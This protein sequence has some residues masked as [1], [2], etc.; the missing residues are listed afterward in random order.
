MQAKLKLISYYTDHGDGS[1]STSFFNSDTE[2]NSY[3]HKR[4]SKLTAELIRRED[5]PYEDG[6]LSNI[7]FN[8]A[9][10]EQGNCTINEPT[11]TSFG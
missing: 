2:L 1:R 4:G 8:L 3:L 6:I 10:D 5:D 11:Y 9:I 7:E